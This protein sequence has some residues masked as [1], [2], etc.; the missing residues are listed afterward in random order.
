VLVVFRGGGGGHGG[1]GGGPLLGGIE[2]GQAR[3]T[4]ASDG[5]GEL[6]GDW[7]E[8]EP[9]PPQPVNQ[10]QVALGAG[11]RACALASFSPI[12]ASALP[13]VCM[14]PFLLPSLR[15]RGYRHLGYLD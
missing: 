13:L 7:M 8:V 14:Y 3:W 12:W 15:A 1:D 4:G 5:D 10:A 2:A 9:V 6:S 11:G